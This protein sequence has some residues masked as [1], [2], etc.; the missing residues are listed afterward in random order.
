MKNSNVY[1]ITG[2]MG[3]IGFHLCKSLLTNPDNK[4]IVFDLQQNLFPTDIKNWKY[5][6]N[7]RK[8]LL[9]NDRF[10]LITANCNDTDILQKTLETYQPGNIIHLAALSVALLSDLYPNDS[11]RNI[12]GTIFTLLNV[13]KNVSFEIERLIYFSSSMVYGHFARDINDNIISASEE[14][15]CNPVDIYGAMKLGG[16]IMVKTYHHRYGIPY[17]VIRPSAVYGPTDCNKRVTEIFLLNALNKE[18][19]TLD[20]GGLHKVDFTYVDDLVKGTIL[21]LHSPEACN[22]TF[23]LSCGEGRSIKEL[24][25]I[26]SELIPGT[27]ITTNQT[28]PYR[29]NRGT[30]NISKAKEILGFNPQYNLEKGIEKYLK[31]VKE[32]QNKIVQLKSC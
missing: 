5:Y 22:Q 11:H 13:L 4:V 32:H 2:G 31:F 7:Y 26:I 28:K 23:N 16:E 15:I 24:A 30:L 12:F 1:F 9:K 8:E 19:L 29:P 3:F 27:K 25:E 10:I 17:T 6:Q 18:P 21:A 14:Q 20:N